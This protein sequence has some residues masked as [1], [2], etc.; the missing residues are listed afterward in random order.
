MSHVYTCE[1]GRQIYRDGKPFISIRREGDTHPTNAD[2]IVHVIVH[3][4][5]LVNTAPFAAFVDALAEESRR[6]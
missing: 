1:A 6:A 4:L 3:V 5:N 2:A